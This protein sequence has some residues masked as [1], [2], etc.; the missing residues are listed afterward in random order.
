MIW[1]MV[2]ELTEISNESFGFTIGGKINIGSKE[3]KKEIQK[4]STRTLIFAISV[5]NH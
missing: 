5:K 1:Q 3:F 4:I 2:S